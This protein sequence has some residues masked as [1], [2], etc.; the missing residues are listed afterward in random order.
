VGYVKIWHIDFKTT[1]SEYRITAGFEASGNKV[2]LNK[3]FM[4]IK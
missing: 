4:V 2:S 3:N 1:G